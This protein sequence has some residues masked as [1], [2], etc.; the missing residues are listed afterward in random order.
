[1]ASIS[2]DKNG[3]R[4]I[5]FVDADGRRRPIRLGKLPMKAAEAIKFKVE[6]LLAAKIAGCA[7][8]AE[9]AR[10]VAGLNEVLADKLAAVDLIPARQSTLLGPFATAY[11]EERKSDSKPSTIVNLE[12]AKALLIAYF[13]ADKKMA[14]VSSGDADSFRSW[15]WNNGAVNTIRRNV[16]RAK[17]LFRAAVRKKIIPENPF[18]GMKGLTV[19]PNKA[20]DFYVTNEMAQAVLAACTKTHWRLLFALARWGGLRTPSEPIRLRW[21]D[22]DWEGG[23]IT[24]TSVKTEAHEGGDQREIPLFPQLR[25]VLE[26]ARAVTPTDA[27]FV[28]TKRSSAKNW[29]TSMKRMIVR[30]GLEPWPKVF[31]NC[32]ASRETELLETFPLHVV[33]AWMGHS[34]KIA[35]LHYARV[36][37]DHFDRAAQIEAQ[38]TPNSGGLA[39]IGAP[40]QQ[41]NAAFPKE[42]GVIS[43]PTRKDCGRHKPASDLGLWEEW[44]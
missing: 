6:Q 9:T 23:R 41:K 5:L 39:T 14:D 26:E 22:I 8:D 38:H 34:P 7:W 40:P 35:L 27:E 16:A 11:I 33:A 18:N 43:S 30:A 4:R 17:Q 29:R 10:F 20:R 2:T 3:N 44:I 13:G 28:I 37:D 19:Q 36:T 15:A 31:Q 1:M 32:R 42:N 21:S 12:R 24:V 25:Q